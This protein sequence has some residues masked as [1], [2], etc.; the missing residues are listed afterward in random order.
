[1]TCVV[2]THT[3]NEYAVLAEGDYEGDPS[4]VIRIYDPF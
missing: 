2:V 3:G 1:M 4:L